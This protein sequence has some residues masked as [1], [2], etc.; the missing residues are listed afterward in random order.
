MSE[1]GPDSSRREFLTTVAAA[2][3][4]L[5]IGSVV[6]GDHRSTTPSV[7]TSLESLACYPLS[8]KYDEQALPEPWLSPDQVP[9]VGNSRLS[10]TSMV[11]KKGLAVA[12]T[13]PGF[14]DADR[15]E[16]EEDFRAEPKATLEERVRL[17]RLVTMMQGKEGSYTKYKQELAHVMGKAVMA[18]VPHISFLE[19]QAALNKSRIQPPF[20]PTKQTYVVATNDADPSLAE[21][22]TVKAPER[23]SKLHTV[24]Q[25]PE[26]LFDAMKRGG[27]HT[28]LVGGEYSFDPYGDGERACLGGTTAMLMEQ[29]FAVRGIAG[30]VFPQVP[31]NVNRHD[32]V[33]QA[34]YERAVAL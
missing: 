5:A 8:Y 1:L 15:Q 30:A 14:L 16:A 6:G 25:H 32:P 11:G 24:L 34:L 3:S 10:G 21:R 29:G 7:E 27:V 23:P 28:V 12:I 26:L 2:S 33:Y 17:H 20:R 31:P 22:V 9:V 19:Q 13:H 4:L 18:D